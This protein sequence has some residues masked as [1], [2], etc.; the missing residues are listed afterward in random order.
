MHGA[1]WFGRPRDV[2]PA[3]SAGYGYGSGPNGSVIEGIDIPTERCLKEVWLKIATEGEPSM[4]SQDIKFINAVDAG[5]WLQYLAKHAVRGVSNYQ[6]SPEN[7][8]PMWKG[9]T[10][11]VWLKGGDWPIEN[12]L[13]CFGLSQADKY[14]YRRLFTR[15]LASLPTSMR[16]RGEE[17]ERV[18]FYWKKWRKCSDVVVSRMRSPSSFIDIET[19]VRLIKSINPDVS[20]IDEVTGEVFE[21]VEDLPVS[22]RANWENPPVHRLVQDMSDLQT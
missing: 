16:I 2:P 17:R 22:R 4:L 11:R 5:H 19:Q 1:F 15:Y 10:G 14:Q 9:K 3:S 6:R 8:P 7:I 21:S 12:R 13:S 18:Q 20:F